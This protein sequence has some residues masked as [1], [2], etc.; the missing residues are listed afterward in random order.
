MLS[1]HRYLFSPTGAKSFRHRIGTANIKRL[2]T[3]YN[4]GENIQAGKNYSLYRLRCSNVIFVY[5]HLLM[6]ERKIPEDFGCGINIAMKVLGGKWKCCIIDMLN[7]GVKRPSEMHRLI[8][9]STPRVIN[10]QL[11]EMEDI[12]AIAKTVY[13]GLPLRVEYYLT[14]LG[15]SILPVINAMEDWGNAHREDVLGAEKE[16]GVAV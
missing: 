6:Y 2:I 13:P 5:K 1:Y 10:M 4:K 7:T 16:V 11:K 14:E 3:S 9:G 12:G 15:K 8:A